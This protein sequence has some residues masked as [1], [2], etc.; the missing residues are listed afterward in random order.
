MILPKNNQKSYGVLHTENYFSFTGFCKKVNS[1][2][3]QSVDIYLDN[4]LI[5]TIL[6]DKKLQN[7]EDIYDIEG[8]GFNYNLSE[9]YIGQK[10]LISFKNHESKEN[11]QN[12]PYKLI[13]INHPNF[14]KYRF[15]HALSEP[16]DEEKIKDLYCPNS[17][18]FLATKEN[19]EDIEYVKYIQILL[20]KFPKVIIKTFYFDSKQREFINNTFKDTLNRFEFII[21]INIYDIANNVEIILCNESKPFDKLV[22]NH[23]ISIKCINILVIYIYLPH[24]KLYL[25]KYD[26]ILKDTGHPLLKHP[27]KFNLDK[28]YIEKVNYSVTKIFTDKF[29]IDINNCTFVEDFYYYQFIKLGLEGKD[30]KKYHLEIFK[31]F[32]A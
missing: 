18:G 24:S 28:D 17:I 25:S 23:N 10:G 27:Q 16:I 15:L 20:L 11:L 14:N 22:F 6:A 26:Q 8:F 12:S 3:I 21:P 2:E 31:E 4:V 7:I 1:N 29:N 19:L 5:D 32:Y 30:I 9:K 13:D